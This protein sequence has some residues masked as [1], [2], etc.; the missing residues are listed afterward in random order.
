MILSKLSRKF[1]LFILVSTILVPFVV[2]A[3]QPSPQKVCIRDIKPLREGGEVEIKGEI[4]IA[5]EV[6]NP[7]NLPL[8]YEWIASDGTFKLSSKTTR[9]AIYVAPNKKGTQIITVQAIHEGQVVDESSIQI[10]VVESAEAVASLPTPTEEPTKESTITITITEPKREVECP[11]GTA[12]IFTIKGTS[13]GV[14]SDSGYQIVPFVNPSPGVP[15]M[16]WPQRDRP[17]VSETWQAE[18]QIGTEEGEEPGHHFEIVALVMDAKTEI[19]VEFQPLPS[20][21]AK[22]NI[23]SLVTA[24]TQVGLTEEPTQEPTEEPTE[25]PV[26]DTPTPTDKPTPIPTPTEPPGTDTPT[27]GPGGPDWCV[28][29]PRPSI[30]NTTLQGKAQITF[31]EN[32]AEVEYINVFAGTSS[33][34]PEDVH[35][36]V[37]VYPKNRRFYPQSDN[38][39]DGLMIQPGDNGNWSITTYLGMPDSGREKFDIVVVLANPEASNFFSEKLKAWAADNS[40]PGLGHGEL[41]NGIMEVQTIVVMRTR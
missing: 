13:T 27:P 20:S 9:S 14:A 15:T 5:F 6:D 26:T 38:A 11:K 10:E 30:S 35:I 19:R 18:A 32:C 37:L 3:C 36:W 17:P 21:I 29:F 31:P 40:W 23:V 34:L 39:A 2:G 24:K 22:S 12:C 28:S 8:T 25:L 41:P 7:D 1:E 4:G 33:D 16:W